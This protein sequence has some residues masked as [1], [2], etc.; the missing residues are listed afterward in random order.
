ML[1]PASEPSECKRICVTCELVKPLT[2][3]PKLKGKPLGRSLT[4]TSCHTEQTRRYRKKRQRQP[5]RTVATKKCGWCK[6]IKP[7]DEFHKD[8]GQNDGLGKY[9][10]VCA[11]R[12]SRNKRLRREY[13]ITFDQY[14]AMLSDQNGRCAICCKRE[15]LVHLGKVARLSVDHNHTTGAARELLCN[16]CNHAIAGLEYLTS[17]PGLLQEAL[18]YLAKHS[19]V[20]CSKL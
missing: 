1:L 17:Q 11:G 15:T 3:F 18:N 13:N 10:K 14:E 8:T 16:R 7:A 6:E 2:V 9:C 4:C 5:K 20:T 19:P 12:K